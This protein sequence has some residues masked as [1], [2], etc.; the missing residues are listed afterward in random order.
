MQPPTSIHPDFI[1]SDDEFI[2]LIRSSKTYAILHQL[3]SLS[4]L[5]EVWIKYGLLRLTSGSIDLIDKEL[6]N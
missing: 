1:K 4:E 3:Y 2:N 6:K 5:D